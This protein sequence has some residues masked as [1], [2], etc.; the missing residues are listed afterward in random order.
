[1]VRVF[2]LSIGILSFPALAEVRIDF[3][4]DIRP[5]LSDRCFRCHG[6]DANAREAELRLDTPEGAFKKNKDGQAPI[7]PGALEKS[8]VWQRITAHDP[9]DVMP[10]PD[11]LR[12]LAGAVHQR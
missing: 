9:D 10:P 3:N 7:V 12:Q 1:M 11:S 6:F 8:A 2:L 4:D 5:L